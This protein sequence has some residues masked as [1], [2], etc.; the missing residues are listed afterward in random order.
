MSPMSY[1]AA[2]LAQ[3]AAIK[4]HHAGACPERIVWQITRACDLAC[5]PCRSQ[6]FNLPSKS[7]LTTEEG[8]D[9]IEEIRRLGQPE[10]ELTGGDPLMRGD[11]LALVQYATRLGLTCGLTLSGTP[12]TTPRM[13][14]LLKT[15]GLAHL[16]FC[17]DGPTA[18][19]HNGYRLE[20]GSYQWTVD[21]IRVAQGI[22]LPIQIETA[23]TTATVAHLPDMAQLVGRLGARVW[24]VTF[25]ER[26]ERDPGDDFALDEHA[27]AIERLA[28]LKG[29]LNYKIRITPAPYFGESRTDRGCASRWQPF[30]LF[31]GDDGTIRRWN[32][33]RILGY[34]RRDRLSDVVQRAAKLAAEPPAELAV[35][36]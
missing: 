26:P 34:V 23:V 25:G 11:L 12:R 18:E 7:Q 10:L 8:L 16:T 35:V 20:D 21:G 28:E 2:R 13:V 5:R 15:A 32:S 14:G 30:E 24:Q 1:K 6:V 3:M 36:G 17:L 22:G 29:T 4:A 19:V 27:T 9:L 31:I 33:G